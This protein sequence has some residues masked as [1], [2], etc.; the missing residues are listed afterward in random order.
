M[1]YGTQHL[2]TYML[3]HI[4]TI[5]QKYPIFISEYGFG[6]KVKC[7]ED[8]GV[9]KVQTIG[10][11]CGVE[12]FD[13][14]IYED[15]GIYYQIKVESSQAFFPDGRILPCACDRVERIFA[16]YVHAVNDAPSNA[17]VEVAA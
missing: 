9:Y 3:E 11:V 2:A 15:S 13:D 6:Q 10:T 12:F 1:T 14:D 7:V 17:K 4:S 16:T 5:F 8:W